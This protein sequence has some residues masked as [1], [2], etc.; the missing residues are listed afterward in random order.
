[1]EHCNTATQLVEMIGRGRFHVSSACSLAQSMKS[2]G[3]EKAPITALAG[4]G[5]GGKYEANQERDLHRW[6][7]GLVELEP[8]TIRLVLQVVWHAD[9]KFSL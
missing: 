9:N 2:D 3:F 8:Y 4:L 1:M 6:L 5:C 7:R